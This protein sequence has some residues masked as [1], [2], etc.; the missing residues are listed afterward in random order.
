MENMYYV[1]GLYDPLKCYPFYIGKGSGKR[2]H[3]HFR[4]SERGTNPYKDNKIDEIKSENRKPYTKKIY[5]NLGENEAYLREHVL[6]SFLKVQPNCKLTNLNYELMKPPVMEGKEN[7]MSNHNFSEEHKRKISK[8][9]KGKKFSEEHKQNLS[10]SKRGE[11][12]H[13]SKLTER[14]A[15]EIKWLSKY[16]NLTQDQIGSKYNVEQ[17]NVSRIKREKPFEKWRVGFN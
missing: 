13:N 17:N 14:K 10:K 12:H 8:A 16:S 2:M 6:M 3:E 15:S 7:P 9:K 11:N 4:K 1:Y 5:Q